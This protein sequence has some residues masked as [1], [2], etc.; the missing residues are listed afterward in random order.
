MNGQKYILMWRYTVWEW[1][2][3]I[4]ESESNICVF[5]LQAPPM[6]NLTDFEYAFKIRDKT[7]PKSWY[8]ADNLTQL[9]PEDKL[10]SSFLEQIRD[11]IKGPGNW[12]HRASLPFAYSA[13]TYS[14][15]V[16][17]W[18]ALLKDVCRIDTELWNSWVLE[19]QL[20]DTLFQEQIKLDN[21][22]ASKGVGRITL[23]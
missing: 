4:L 18:R 6:K 22:G 21:C 15:F 11:R 17:V 14:W 13:R 7:D 10:G 2:L 5:D 20:R 3:C 19:N 9:P 16:S 12:V 1:D 23:V 8:Q